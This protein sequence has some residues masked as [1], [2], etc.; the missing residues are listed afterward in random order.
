MAATE[1]RHGELDRARP[2]LLKSLEEEPSSDVL[3][4]LVAI[5]RQ[6]GKLSDALGWA[7]KAVEA[8][9]ASAD[10]LTEADAQIT[11]FELFREECARPDRSRSRA[12]KLR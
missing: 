8:S 6:R 10:L 7:D 4:L 9:R 5:D 3:L 1:I 12:S 11:R 2:L